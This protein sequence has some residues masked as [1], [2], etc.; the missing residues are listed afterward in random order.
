M[1]IRTETINDYKHVFNLN[2][3]AFEKRDDEAKLVEHIR[4]SN[5]FIRELSLV[6]EEQGK[7]VGHVLFSKAKIIRENEETDVLVLAPIAVNPT[8]QKRGIGSNLIRAGLR[9]AKDLG[10]GLV[11]LIGHPNYYPKFGFQ[12]ARNHGME[13]TQFEVPDDVFMVCELKDGELARISG[14]LHYP[15]SF[16]I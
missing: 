10:Y 16:F 5:C 4:F 1:Q 15:A 2:Y 12:S 14:E 6:A 3:L 8:F 7:I 13:L 9:R 11:F